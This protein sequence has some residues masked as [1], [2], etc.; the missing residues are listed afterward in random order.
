MSGRTRF[1]LTMG[2]VVWAIGLA[3]IT[4]SVRAHVPTNVML[5]LVVGSGL[6]GILITATLFMLHERPFAGPEVWMCAVDYSYE[7]GMTWCHTYATFEDL[8]EHRPCVRE[9]GAVRVRLSA[10]ERFS[11]SQVEAM[12]RKGVKAGDIEPQVKG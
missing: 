6:I 11:E 2:S 1:L 3:L 8:A 7:A 5:P 4:I 12:Y 9:C 10:F